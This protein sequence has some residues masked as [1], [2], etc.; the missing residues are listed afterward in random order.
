LGAILC[1]VLAGCGEEG[2]PVPSDRFHRLSVGAP[3]TVYQTPK[4]NGVVEIDRFH[5]T[6]VLQNRAIVFV[7]TDSPHVMHQYH[8]QLWADD[9][10]RMLQNVTLEYLRDARVADEV[11]MT[12]FRIDPTYTLIGDIKKL[13]HV[14]GNSSSVVVELEF[15]LREH[16]NG[17]V[18]WAKSY[19]AGRKVK[20]DSV[21]AATRAISESVREILTRLSADLAK[22]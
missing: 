17:S 13:E 4:L 14:V 22:R 10:T 20:D 3:D 21:A 19:S 8:Y 15:G 6:G 18:V 16:K 2:I 12:G 9:P 1:G 7:E 5:A 11:V